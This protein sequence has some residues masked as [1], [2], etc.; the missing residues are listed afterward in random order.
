[1]DLPGQDVAAPTFSL[2]IDPAGSLSTS[3]EDLG[4]FLSMLFADGQGKKGRVVQPATLE[5]MYK[6]QFPAPDAKTGFGLGFFVRDFAGHRS[7]G[8]N[9]AIYGF[10]TSLAALPK[11]K[12]G[13][14]VVAS[15]DCAECR[16]RQVGRLRA[17]GDA[18]RPRWPAAARLS[19]YEGAAA[20]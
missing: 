20:G 19:L 13:V 7:V 10:A 14:A 12:L 11:E 4:L 16:N 3:V 8:H 5:A 18:G 17:Q 1:M 2:G 15:L 9:G 6:V